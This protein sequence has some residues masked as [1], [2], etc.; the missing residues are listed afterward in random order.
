MQLCCSNSSTGKL[1]YY[2]V[3]LDRR[4]RRDK[5]YVFAIKPTKD[6]FLIAFSIA[7]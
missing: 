7:W 4:R 3:M 6:S 2:T 1:G 5:V